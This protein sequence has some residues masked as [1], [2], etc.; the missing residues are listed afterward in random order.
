[1][2]TDG[3]T[4]LKESKAGGD[5]TLEDDTVCAGDAAPLGEGTTYDGKTK[6][7]DSK[8][9]GDADANDR[10]HVQMIRH[11]LRI[12]HTMTRPS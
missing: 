9:V 8:A 2:S 1:M 4:E 12:V 6:L 7:N 3:T 11:R 5:A 10:R